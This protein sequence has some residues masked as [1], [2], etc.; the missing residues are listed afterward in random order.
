MDPPSS[1]GYVALSMGPV[2][3]YT[4]NDTGY[5]TI[6][7]PVGTRIVLYDLDPNAT[8]SDVT[9]VRG[10]NLIASVKDGQATY[11]HY[12]AHGD[13]VQLTDSTGA[14][15]KNYEYDAFGV[16]E[17]ADEYDANLF[18]YCG[19]QYDAETGNYYLRARYYTPG[20]GRF[21]QEDPIRDGL[22][23]YTY[24]AGN[25]VVFVDPSG[26]KM[27]KPSFASS[28]YTEFYSRT[29]GEPF[30]SIRQIAK[31]IQTWQNY[32]YNKQFSVSGLINGQ[33][34]SPV[35]D[36]KYGG[37]DL[38]WS[39]CEV[40]ANYNALIILD[41]P[42]DLNDVANWGE[43]HGQILDGIFGTFPTSSKQLFEY[44][45]YS[46]TEEMDSSKFDAQAAKGDVCIF[47]FTN[48]KGTITDGVHTVAVALENNRIAVYNEYGQDTAPGYYNSFSDM[49]SSK[50]IGAW[51]LYVISK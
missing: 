25:P 42:Q 41:N 2:Y 3:F 26:Q 33:L 18:R 16:E 11:Y 46:V 51:V 28:S 24:C 9:Y 30:S 43:N 19:E 31:G 36:Y 44:L 37:M 17:N 39:G 32:E 4:N 40:I 47:T 35:S 13:V 27:L 21:T 23:W 29:I 7:G 38:G 10:L 12:N 8:Q 34:R 45:G 49:I 1:L 48:T 50:N 20:V 5:T 22:N 15:V 6:S 14:L